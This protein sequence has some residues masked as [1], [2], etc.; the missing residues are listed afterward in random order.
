ME[1][2]AL[3]QT[4]DGRQELAKWLR[5]H[6]IEDVSTNGAIDGAA[7]VDD[8]AALCALY[9]NCRPFLRQPRV[10]Q[11]ACGSDFTL[12]ISQNGDVYSWGYGERGQLG[13]GQEDDESPQR[14]P[15]RIEALRE[16][17]DTYGRVTQV[18]CGEAHV[19][20]LTEHA[21]VIA[22]GESGMGQ[23][24]VLLGQESNVAAGAADGYGSDDSC[25]TSEMSDVDSVVWKPREITELLP[26][27]SP[28]GIDERLNEACVPQRM[29]CEQAV[30]DR[31][32]Q[33]AA[34]AEHSLALIDAG[35]VL[36]WGKAG[37][38][39]NGPLGRRLS[40]KEKREGCCAMPKLVTTAP[41]AGQNHGD[42]L[43]DMCVTVH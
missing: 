23:C 2:E 7:V 18:A 25:G 17:I 39:G 36:S 1:A 10:V 26:S 37:F 41:R 14:S 30:G 21:S 11:V 38:G 24:G 31:V 40:D 15:R 33:V 8:C 5:E 3:A 19:L 42:F 9:F 27:P 22:W 16:K 29:R 20:A 13:H 12:A 34:G 6:C 32:I 43:F 28:I 4:R 35:H